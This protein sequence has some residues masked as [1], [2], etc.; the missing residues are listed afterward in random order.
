MYFIWVIPLPFYLFFYENIFMEKT[1]KFS[2]TKSDV[3][4]YKALYFNEHQRA[5]KPPIDKPQ[6]PSLNKYMIMNN[7]AANNLKQN[8]K[9]FIIWVLEKNNLMGL[10]I[11]K[12]S[13]KY[14]TYFAINRRHDL[15]NISPKYIFDG[16]VAGGFI[17]D[18]DSEHI[19]SLTT[20]CFVDKENPRI[21]LIVDIME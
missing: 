15:D 6:H 17:V 8:W 1:I 14:I 7:H 13:V 12:C 16:L 2:I 4:E 10:G 19:V 20:Q 18:D 11:E 21:E 3:D 5:K 9:R